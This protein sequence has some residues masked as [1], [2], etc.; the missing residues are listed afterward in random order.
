MEDIL[1]IYHCPYVDFYA[2]NNAKIP[3]IGA[4]FGV[5]AQ[6]EMSL[7]GAEYASVRGRMKRC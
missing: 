7:R 5:S 3:I 2:T 1:E 4:V 6:D